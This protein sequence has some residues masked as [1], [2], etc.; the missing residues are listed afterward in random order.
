M[1]NLHQQTQTDIPSTGKPHIKAVMLGLVFAFF[2]VLLSVIAIAGYSYHKLTT[3][4]TAANTSIT[5]VFELVKAGVESQPTQTNGYKTILLLGVD[6]V[7]NKPESPL[8]TDTMM[9]LSVHLESGAIRTLA[10]PR[11]LWSVEY[12]TRINALYHY[13]HERYPD[14]PQ[15]FPQEVI[16]QMTG[17]PI[18][19]TVVLSLEQVAEIID[20]LGGIKI[21]VPEGF[22]DTQ[23][24]RSDVNIY[25][26]SSDELYQTITFEPGLQYMSGERVLQY[27]RS[28][29]S[30]NLAQGTDTARSQR[31]QQ[32]IAAIIQR[33]QNFSVLKNTSTLVELYNYYTTNFESQ[34]SKQEIISTGY[35][36]FPNKD[37]ISFK[38]SNL[39]IYPENEFGVITN[40]PAYKYKGEWVYE[41]RDIQAFQEEVQLY[42]QGSE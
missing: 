3:L 15:Q 26:A 38:S 9:L 8:L 30:T 16:A 14:F 10:L 41:V 36:L 37:S 19:H 40:P 28:R 42:L 1:S 25:T 23:F 18:E 4:A 7:E 2:I 20:L 11:D 12:Q 27:I 34:L 6:S 24:P 22:T 29:K 32:V 13:G 21:D 17:I 35:T 39:S 33:M 5:E 31:Q